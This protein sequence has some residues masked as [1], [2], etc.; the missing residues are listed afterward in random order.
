MKRI[1]TYFYKHPALL[2]IAFTMTAFMPALLP[3]FYIKNDLVTQI[4]PT[5]FVISESLHSGFFPWWNPY[6]NY[7]IPQY[8]DMNCGFW[9]P[10]LWIIAL[11]FRY[12]IWVI[13]YEELF[14]IFLSGW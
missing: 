2:F 12:D 10:I 14:Y 3:F 5:R 8:S 1:A 6:I 4:L 7:G 9:N 13:T 11:F